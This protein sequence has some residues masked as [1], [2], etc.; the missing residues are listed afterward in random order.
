M[1]DL[2]NQAQLISRVDAQEIEFAPGEIDLMELCNG[3]AEAARA[4]HAD[5]PC[6]LET[7]FSLPHL[8]GWFDPTLLRYIIGNLLS[9]AFKYSPNGGAIALRVSRSTKQT[10]LEVQ[11]H[12]IGIPNAD[13][14][15]LFEP[16][17]R[18]SNVGTIAGTGLG[19]T[20]VRKAVDLHGG[21]IQVNSML[22]NFTRF[23]VTLW[24]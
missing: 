15:T 22:S 3:M 9:N 23:T 24:E 12:G 11:D 21:T 10:V 16:F 2:L 8:V 5:S 17:Q 6:T 18:G 7:Q 19:L 20:I 4:Q 13:M 14:A 1:T